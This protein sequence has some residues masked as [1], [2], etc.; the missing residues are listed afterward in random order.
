MKIDG[1][2]ILTEE[3]GIYDIDTDELG[4]NVEET[5][6]WLANN[7]LLQESRDNHNHKNDK[8]WLSKLGFIPAEEIRKLDILTQFSKTGLDKVVQEAQELILTNVER[9]ISALAKLHLWFGTDWKQSVPKGYTS[10]EFGKLLPGTVTGEEKKILLINIKHF[11]KCLML[12]NR[13]KYF[14]ER[15]SDKKMY[16]MSQAISIALRF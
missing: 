11:K 7:Q 5:V 16:T 15:C 12:I 13:Y 3:Y 6:E 1:M 8:I 4:E 2:K 14:W 10:M 9:D